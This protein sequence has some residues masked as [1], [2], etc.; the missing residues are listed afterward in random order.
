M[1]NHFSKCPEDIDAG[2]KVRFLSWK[3]HLSC[4]L[5]SKHKHLIRDKV[6]DLYE[7]YCTRGLAIILKFKKPFIKLQLKSSE[8]KC[9][10]FSSHFPQPIMFAPNLFSNRKTNLG[11]RR[12]SHSCHWKPSKSH[13]SGSFSRSLL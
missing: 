12:H 13:F 5:R 9:S 2:C 10:K 8:S 7:T 3:W 1:L 11:R 4:K 6:S